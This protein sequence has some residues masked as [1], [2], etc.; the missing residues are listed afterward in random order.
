MK[1]VRMDLMGIPSIMCLWSF[2]HILWILNHPIAICPEWGRT[3]QPVNWDA[4][5]WGYWLNEN[6]IYQMF[7]NGNIMMIYDNYL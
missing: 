1:L 4:L 2:I 7:G 3:L 5:G 6:Y